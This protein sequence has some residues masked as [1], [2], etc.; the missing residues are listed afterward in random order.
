MVPAGAMRF[1]QTHFPRSV[2]EVAGV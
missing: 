2:S 1:T